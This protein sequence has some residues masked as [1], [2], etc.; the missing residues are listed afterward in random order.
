MDNWL[1]WLIIVLTIGLVIF[2]IWKDRT[3]FPRFVALKKSEDRR[4]HMRNWLFSGILKFSGLGVLGLFLLGHLDALTGF[5]DILSDPLN[6][7]LNSLGIGDSAAN[8][9]L[10]AFVGVFVL[11]MV[12][13]TIL[14]A[15]MDTSEMPDDGVFA[16]LPRNP[17]EMG[18]TA[19]LSVNAGIGEEIFFR[20]LLPIAVIEATGSFSA[21]L[22]ICTLLFGFA[23]GYQG[24]VGVMTTMFVGAVFLVIYLLS[25]S[26]WF[27][28]ALH[29][30]TDL[31]GLVILPL[32]LKWFDR[33]PDDVQESG[34]TPANVLP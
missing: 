32:I 33:F 13:L 27:V 14:P 15:L 2:Q 22:L 7:L 29:I 8:L 6:S 30:A 16:M 34:E 3:A 21:A 25:G 9:I 4:K 31:R 1:A 12:V 10:W 23:H 17:K 5:P 18:W 24:I 26:L 28:M 11:I 19:A 20:C